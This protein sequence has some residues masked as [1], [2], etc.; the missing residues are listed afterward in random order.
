M[1]VL[2]SRGARDGSEM[3]VIMNMS[4][5]AKNVI[6]LEHEW[7][8]LINGQPVDKNNVSRTVYESWQRSM[9][10]GA[11]PNNN[12]KEIVLT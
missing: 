5:I 2:L 6:A 10:V 7:N 3:E 9:Q 8:N 1:L 11:D 12:G 4:I